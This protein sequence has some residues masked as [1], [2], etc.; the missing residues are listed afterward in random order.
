MLDRKNPPSHRVG[1]LWK[2]QLS[3]LDEWVSAGGADE[4]KMNNSTGKQA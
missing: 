1:R 2:F 4:N 3:E